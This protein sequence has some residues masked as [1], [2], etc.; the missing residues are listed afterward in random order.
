MSAAWKSKPFHAARAKKKKGW[1]ECLFFI[2]V[3][4][5]IAHTHVCLIDWRISFRLLISTM[6]L[7]FVWFSSDISQ[8]GR[9]QFLLNNQQK[10][11]DCCIGEA[12]ALDIDAEQTLSTHVIVL[13]RIEEYELSEYRIAI[14]KKKLV[15]DSINWKLFVS[16]LFKSIFSTNSAEIAHTNRALDLALYNVS[17]PLLFLV[18]SSCRAEKWI[19][20]FIWRSNRL[21]SAVRF[22]L[23]TGCIQP[24]ASITACQVLGRRYSPSLCVCVCVCLFFIS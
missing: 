23:H 10:Y 18:L 21:A 7:P 2:F 15:L 4:R 11:V 17:D 16:V 14:E 13:F 20:R 1:S 22:T 19:F 8:G 6:R 9:T 5:F 3:Q 12:T 24:V